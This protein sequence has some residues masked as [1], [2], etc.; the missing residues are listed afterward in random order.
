MILLGSMMRFEDFQG[1]GP[2]MMNQ[3][4]FGFFGFLWLIT[5]ILII[6]GLAG[7]VRWMWKKGDN[8]KK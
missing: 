3:G 5:W 2:Y 6:L 8:V 7:F 1:Q 4:Y